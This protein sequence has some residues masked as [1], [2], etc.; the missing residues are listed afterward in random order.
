MISKTWKILW[1]SHLE[2]MNIEINFFQRNVFTSRAVEGTPLYR[3][4]Y[5][6][7]KWTVFVYSGHW[8][9]SLECVDITDS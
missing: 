5:E 4:A 7:Q 3:L 8:A 6:F 9:S 1:A 2:A